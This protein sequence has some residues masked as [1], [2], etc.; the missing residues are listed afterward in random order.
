[1]RPEIIHTADFC[2]LNRGFQIIFVWD[3]DKLLKLEKIWRPN[4]RN[5]KILSRKLF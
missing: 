2:E 3:Q 5:N 4:L 1:M